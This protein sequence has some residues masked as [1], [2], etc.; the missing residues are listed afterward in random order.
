MGR[1]RVA[2]FHDFAS[3]DRAREHGVVAKDFTCGSL[4]R[5]FARILTERV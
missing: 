1:K 5:N 3:I 2:P 4:A